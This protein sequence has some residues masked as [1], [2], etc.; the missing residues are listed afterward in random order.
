MLVDEVPAWSTHLRSR[1]RLT[2]AAKRCLV[3]PSLMVALLGAD[4]ARLRQDLETFGFVFESM[5]IR[6]LRTCA[7]TLDAEVFHYRERSGRLEVDLV[8]ERRDG[9]WIGVEVRLGN[10]RVDQA[11]AALRALAD[12]RVTR[13]PAALVVITGSG[14]AYRRPDG[15][16][17]VPVT[18]LRP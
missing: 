3:D 1:T 14:Y 13:R 7:Q 9:A 6:D 4:A 2:Q 8:V 17:V 12:Q 11:A 18:T 15:V 5:V 10:H 16:D